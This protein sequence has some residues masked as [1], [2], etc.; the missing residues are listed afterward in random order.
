MRL[1]VAL[2]ITKLINVI[3]VLIIEVLAIE[4]LI[5][6]IIEELSISVN[7]CYVKIIDFK[8]IATIILRV[9]SIKSIFKVDLVDRGLFF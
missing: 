1:I 7:N 6:D 3:E 4:V 2:F 8:L 9:V 5:L